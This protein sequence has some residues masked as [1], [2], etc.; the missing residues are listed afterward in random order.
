MHGLLR[1]LFYF[2]DDDWNI[3]GQSVFTCENHAFRELNLYMC[4]DCGAV[5][6]KEM[7]GESK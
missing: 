2:Y 7:A 4:V 5:F 1:P 3:K 6:A